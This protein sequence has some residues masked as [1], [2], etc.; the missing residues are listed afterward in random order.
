MSVYLDDLHAPIDSRI[1]VHDANQFEVKLDYAID[2]AR[3]QSRYRIEAYFFVPSSLGINPQT[4]SREQFYTDIQAYIR[5]KTPSVSLVSLCDPNNVESPLWRIQ[6]LLPSGGRSRDSGTLE[7][8]SYELRLLACLI[9]AQVRDRALAACL[10]LRELPATLPRRAHGLRAFSHACASL[11]DELSITLRACRDLRPR[12]MASQLPPWLRE[13]YE[14]V[15]EYLSVACEAQ[16]TMILDAVDQAPEATSSLRSS[17]Q[18][19]VELLSREQGSRQPGSDV[20]AYVPPQGDESHLY[21]RGLLKKFI[22]SVL[23][24]EVSKQREDRAVDFAAAMAAGIAMLFA[25]IAAMATQR[26]YAL[27]SWPFVGALVASY[28][29]KDRLKDWTKRYFA[30]RLTQHLWDYNVR[31]EDPHTRRTLGRCREA[32]SHLSSAQVPADVLQC[33]F[34]QALSTLEKDLKRE[35]V[36]RYEKD[37]YLLGRTIGSL[38]GRLHEINDIIRFNIATFLTR[39]DDPVRS[40]RFYD[41]SSDSVRAVDCPKVYH[42]NVVFVLRADDGGEPRHIERV[43]VVLD[44]RGIRRIE[45]S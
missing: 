45:S 30:A 39:T 25:S 18:R 34:A 40:L 31:I 33:R 22:M 38:Y 1:G 41:P 7:R 6:M 3:E 8:L 24:L 2:P 23:F 11:V 5:F 36:L 44:K 42:L 16:L 15:D 29:L 9:R 19:L 28:V 12:F 32:F 27:N 35:K 37:V 14:Y 4:Y 43:R 17:R 13:V 20:S 10:L 21:R 26:R